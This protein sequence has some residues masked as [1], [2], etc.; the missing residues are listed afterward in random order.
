[1]TNEERLKIF[2]EVDPGCITDALICFKIGA[3]MQGIFPVSKKAKIYGRAVTARFETVSDPE[4]IL[5]PYEIIEMG[6]PGDVLVWNVDMDANIMGENIFHFIKGHGLNGIV[7]EG[8]I[9]DINEIEEIGGCVF[10]KGPAAYSAPVNFRPTKKT[11]NVPVTV[12]G[13]VV[14]PGD[15]I[16]G[17]ANGVMVVPWEYADIVLEQ[18]RLNMVWEKEL[19]EAIKAG[20]NSEQMREVYGHLKKIDINRNQII[21]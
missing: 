9:R 12:G 18:A 5:T 3:W 4:E 10:S 17:D 19:E 6:E 11:V 14:R 20:Y 16:C 15:Y 13:A 21:K 7:L 1:M 2:E 8:K